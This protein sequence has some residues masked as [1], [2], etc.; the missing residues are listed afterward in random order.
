MN[1]E[2][3]NDYGI[4]EGQ[5]DIFAI[6]NEEVPAEN[7]VET[8]P[9]ENAQEPEFKLRDESGAMTLVGV[10][11]AMADEPRSDINTS[12]Y[13][14]DYYDESQK[15]RLAHVAATSESEARETFDKDPEHRKHQFIKATPSR[16]SY[17]E[18]LALKA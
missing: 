10:L 7:E 9:H 6:L 8:T 12:A 16:R 17:E 13:L 1:Y 15:W 3:T 11:E 14:V 4:P 2:Q 5:L 18:L